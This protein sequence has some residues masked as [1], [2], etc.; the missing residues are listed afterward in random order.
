MRGATFTRK[1]VMILSNLFTIIYT[2]SL[3]LKKGEKR[4]SERKYSSPHITVSEMS[5]EF[6]RYFMVNMSDEGSMNPLFK[7]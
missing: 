5:A 4:I 1:S 3:F 6:V 7:T 2:L